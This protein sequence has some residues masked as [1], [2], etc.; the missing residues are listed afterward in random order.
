M[1]SASTR[2]KLPHQIAAADAKA[3]LLR[4]LATVA[5]T[6]EYVIT[7]RGKPIARLVPFEP[8]SR[9]DIYGCMKKYGEVSIVG[10][11]IGPEPDEW[12]ALR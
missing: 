8:E 9:P 7:K 10:D 12:D 3:N 6:G 4:M 11:I 1:S 2:R 5:E